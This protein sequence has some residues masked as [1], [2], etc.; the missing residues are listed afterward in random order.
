MG[1]TPDE[2]DAAVGQVYFQRSFHCA[3]FC[4]LFPSAAGEW[5]IDKHLFLGDSLEMSY[6]PQGDFPRRRH[7]TRE[8]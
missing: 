2:I 6:P 4:S 8:R 7:D 1:Q 3:L 5:R